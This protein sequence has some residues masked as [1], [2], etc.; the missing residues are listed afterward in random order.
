MILIDVTLNAQPGRRE[1]LLRL[2]AD[3]AAASRQ[4][5]GCV[6]YRFTAS[7][8]QRDVFHLVELWRDEASLR[9]HYAG[10]AFRRFIDELPALG[11]VESSV[12]RAGDLTPYAGGA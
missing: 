2:F 8:E 3:T 1:E 6:T 4:E 7:L 11:K 12:K 9:Q 5:D 10:A